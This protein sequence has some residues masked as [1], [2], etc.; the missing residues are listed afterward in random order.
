MDGSPTEKRENWVDTAKS[1]CGKVSGS[2]DL[3]RGGLRAT[4]TL[5]VVM[6]RDLRVMQF[7]LIY[8]FIQIST[9]GAVFYLPAE[10]SALLHKSVGI[11][12]GLVSAIPWI[13][14]LAAVYF[15]PR[16][17]DKFQKHRQLASLTLVIS[18]C[19]SFAFPTAGPRMGL[20]TLS[21]AVAGF[22]AVQIRLWDISNER[23]GGM[24]QLRTAQA[25]R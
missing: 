9:Y 24:R 7:L 11:E 20:V 13:C 14:T 22:I 21:L 23:I 6:F 15:L 8:T 5:P 2:C 4:R 17:A 19:A 18:G 3:V 12:V 1:A 10:I 25:V 16:A